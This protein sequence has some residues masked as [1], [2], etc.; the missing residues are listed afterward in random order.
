MTAHILIIEFFDEACLTF[1]IHIDTVK[2]SFVFRSNELLD[3][4][5]S[6]VKM[7]KGKNSLDFIPV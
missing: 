6:L 2:S 3:N 1:V 5:A 4:V 7:T